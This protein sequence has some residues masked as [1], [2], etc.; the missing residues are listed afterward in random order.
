MISQNAQFFLPAAAA[1]TM[2]P[3]MAKTV[4]LPGGATSKRSNTYTICATKSSLGWNES[5][6]WN[7]QHKRM[8]VYRPRLMTRNKDARSCCWTV[9]RSG[10][11]KKHRPYWQAMRRCH[12][13]L[14]VSQS[15]TV[16][17]RARMYPCRS[18]DCNDSSEYLW[19][20]MIAGILWWTYLFS[21]CRYAHVRMHHWW[22]QT[23]CSFRLLDQAACYTNQVPL[24]GHQRT[25][26]VARHAG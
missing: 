1:A 9:W 11:P 10:I 3:T 21:V 26:R 8:I 6:L 14:S 22:E 13:Y 24:R 5:L 19:L 15:C 12:F 2:M 7:K 25:R 17:L 16:S 20:W 4:R 18:A 23:Q